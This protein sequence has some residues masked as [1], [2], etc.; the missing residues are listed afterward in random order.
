MGVPPDI[1]LN[2]RLV[3]PSLVLGND[4]LDDGD[5]PLPDLVAAA[6]QVLPQPVE[7]DLGDD[8]RAVLG[9]DAV[10]PLQGHQE[11]SPAGHDR[12][13]VS[14]DEVELALAES[15]GKGLGL[16]ARHGGKGVRDVALS[17]GAAAD[18]SQ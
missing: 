12:I 7:L 11:T 8:G 17:L 3:G 16:P 15:I 2:L 14:A 10:L 5:A 18:G 9:N 6:C 4:A 1:V 13:L